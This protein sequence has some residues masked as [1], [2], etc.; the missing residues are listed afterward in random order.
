MVRASF[1][2]EMLLPAAG[3]EGDCFRPVSSLV[4]GDRM[5][6]ASGEEIVVAY[7]NSE[8][9]STIFRMVAGDRQPLFVTGS[10]RVVVP[11]PRN[12]TGT[13]TKCAE[14]LEAGD[15]VMCTDGPARLDSIEKM[16]VD[17]EVWTITFARDLAVAGPGQAILTKGKPKFRRGPRKPWQRD[18]AEPA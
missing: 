16:E 1:H 12:A 14:F 5:L 17:L 13:A 8:R 3:G 11:H 10:H 4:R 15:V 7:I 18:G 6:A 9:V 2:P